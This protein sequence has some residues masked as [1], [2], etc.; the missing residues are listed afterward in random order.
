M[1][2]THIS[3]NCLLLIVCINFIVCALVYQELVRKSALNKPIKIQLHCFGG[4]LCLQRLMYVQN[5]NG[6]IGGCVCAL[7]GEPVL[8]R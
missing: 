8:K 3:I 2:I 7:T 6:E 5:F 4:I 1:R